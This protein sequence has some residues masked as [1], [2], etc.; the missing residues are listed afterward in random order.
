MF[1]FYYLFLM[2]NLFVFVLTA[3]KAVLVSFRSYGPQ[4]F[5]V[6]TIILLIFLLLYEFFLKHSMAQHFTPQTHR[7]IEN[8][9]RKIKEIS[10]VLYM[11]TKLR[12]MKCFVI[13][14]EGKLAHKE[15]LC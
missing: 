3:A 2:L 4:Q 11:A 7:S 8:F 9:C 15:K 1:I 13:N 6:D 10:N 5:I 14:F 12:L